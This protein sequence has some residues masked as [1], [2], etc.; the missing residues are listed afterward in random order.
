MPHGEMPGTTAPSVV[1]PSIAKNTLARH[2]QVHNK[3]RALPRTRRKAC[4]ACCQSKTRCNAQRPSCSSCLKRGLFCTYESYPPQQTATPTPPDTGL[5]NSI[6][7][8]SPHEE[9]IANGRVHDFLALADDNLPTVIAGHQEYDPCVSATVEEP[10]QSPLANMLHGLAPPGRDL[11]YSTF[12][13]MDFH[14][15]LDWMLED[16]HTGED[17]INTSD[18]FGIP[19]LD[20]N[21]LSQT[22]F[23]SVP[24]TASPSAGQCI[25]GDEIADS[26]VTGQGTASP[27]ALCGLLTPHPQET[28]DAGNPWPMETPRP[29]QRHV[30]LPA[31]SPAGTSLDVSQRY[32]SVMALNNRTWH[33]LRK[34]LMLPVDRSSLQSLS[35]DEFPTMDQLDHCIDLYF[36][37]FHDMLPV[38]HLPTFDPGKDLV[39]TLAMICIGSCYSEFSGAKAFSITLSELIRRLLLFM[40]EEDRRFVRTGSH[41]TAQLL[42]G[43]HGYCSGN[44]RLFELSESCRSTLVHHA[45]CMGLFHAD[46]NKPSGPDTTTD[47]SWHQWIDAE[48]LRRL[49]WAVYKY[50]ASVA[51]LHNNR[52]FLSTGDIN[53]N[54]PSS[55]EHWNAES[56]QAWAS[57]HPWTRAVPVS[58]RLRPTIRL[59]FDG[60]TNPLQKIAD[61]EHIFLVVITLVRMLWTL[62]EIRSSP[63]NDLTTPAG[64]N[65]GRETLLRALDRMTI[66]VVAFSKSHTRQEMSRLVHRVQLIHVAHIYGAGDLMN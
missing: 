46:V 23:I 21:Q 4:I 25:S 54:L 41:L 62:K 17:F 35:V 7:Q 15:N 53:L 55:I 16:S 14:S 31:L 57:L 61:D 43:T 18:I 45:K 13:D 34:C 27:Q 29:P 65:D 66:P 1:A 22:F 10:Y 60:T 12:D 11:L 2:M 63:I 40:A 56:A 47:K 28:A 20:E 6:D 52:P 37:H 8:G 38:I 59:M 39:V 3:Q 50:D 36:A 49:G 42:Q 58:P 64:F 5:G 19:G 44:E 26:P 9:V 33:A 48:R 51:Y 32:F 30:A 24:Q